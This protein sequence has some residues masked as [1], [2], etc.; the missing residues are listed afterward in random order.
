[1]KEKQILVILKNPGEEARVEP[2]FENSLEA[3]QKA[4]GG[5][6]ESVIFASDAVIICNEDGRILGLPHNCNVL[7]VDF[8]G[9]ILIVGIKGEEFCSLRGSSVSRLLRMVRE[10]QDG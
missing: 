1:M 5:Y 3:F 9:P 8:V 6:I 4:V 2:L 10:R 7:G